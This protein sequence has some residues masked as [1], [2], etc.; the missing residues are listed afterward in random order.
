[1][2]EAGREIR[3]R[4]RHF[5]ESIPADLEKGRSRLAV[6]AR[7]R[8]GSFETHHFGVEVQR[9]LKILDGNSHVVQPQTVAGLLCEAR[10]NHHRSHH[11]S[12]YEKCQSTQINE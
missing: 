6:R 11:D 4:W 9:L 3:R 10:R 7:H 2:R 1:M 12:R 5:D 8:V